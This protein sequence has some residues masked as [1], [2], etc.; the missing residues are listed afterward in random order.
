MSVPS[1]FKI[2][3]ATEHDWTSILSI[4][5][6]RYETES[7]SVYSIR[8][9]PLLHGRTCW[10]AEIGDKIAGYCL[11]AREDASP[12]IGWL[13][14]AVVLKDYESRGIGSALCSQCIDEFRLM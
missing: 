5:R 4:E 14:S 9:M 8:M 3:L 6:L 2:R 11:G 1:K 7:Y 10:V 12:D 13:L